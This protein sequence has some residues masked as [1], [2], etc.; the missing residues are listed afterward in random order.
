MIRVIGDRVLVEEIDTRMKKT[1]SGI[2]IPDAAVE[3]ELYM[4]G[5]VKKIGPGRVK[6]DGTFIPVSVS[7]GDVVLYN[8][9]SGDRVTVGDS[10]MRILSEKT[11][12]ALVIGD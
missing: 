7:V 9:N 2:I 10:K 12:V 8:R 5:V 3:D 11:I 4:K 6:D 1:K